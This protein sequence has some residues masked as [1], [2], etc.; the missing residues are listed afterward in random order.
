MT[1]L[2]TLFREYS[3]LFIVGSFCVIFA[4][5][6][7]VLTNVQARDSISGNPIMVQEEAATNQLVMMSFP[8]LSVATSG[9]L[10]DMSAVTYFQHFASGTVEVSRLEIGCESNSNSTTTIKVGVITRTN[11]AGNQQDVHYFDQFRCV[12]GSNVTTATLNSRYVADYSPSRVRLSLNQ[13][14]TTGF[15]SDDVE[16]AT[17]NFATTTP[18]RSPAARLINSGDPV[19]NFKTF[20]QRG[21]LVVRI[22]SVS[23]AATPTIKAF[24]RVQPTN[25]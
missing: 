3:A 14:T 4:F 25:P 12:T 7:F 9:V 10:V 2:N 6:F 1:K 5:L 15:I 20:P 13:A 18:L 21:D 23:G 22:V 19:A 8:N 11:F 17:N 24:Y 16:L